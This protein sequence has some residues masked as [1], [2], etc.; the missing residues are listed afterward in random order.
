MEFELPPDAIMLRDML[1]K[2][3]Q[4]EAR[5]LE[6]KYFTSG[7]LEPKERLRLR[8]AIEQMGL[9]GLTVPEAYGGGLDTVSACLIEEELGK[10]FIPLDIGEVAAPLYACQ[11]GQAARYLEPA[12]A[13]ER[14]CVLAVREPGPDGYKPERW[15]TTAEPN[16][17]LQN[18][19]AGYTL[20]GRK[21]LAALPRAEDFLIVYAAS[22]EGITAFLLDANHPGLSFGGKGEVILEI[23]ECQVGEDALLGEPGKALGLGAEEAPRAWIRTGARYL[24]IVERLIEMSSEHARDWV[25]LGAA[26]A[27]RP[28]V[29]RML[30]E[31]RVDVESARWLVYHAAWLADTGNPDAVRLPAAQVRLATGEML[32]R[33]VDRATMLFAGPGPSDQIEPNRLVHSLVPP[34]ALKLALEQARAAIA[35]DMLGTVT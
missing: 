15:A 9:W 22:P 21:S 3:I 19:Q 34:Q 31:M 32:Q 23:A 24:G 10:T 8:Q 33:S 12:L 1:R 6:M 17:R 4:K 14:R 26:L 35:A 13:G 7:D 30:A 18:P 20:H 29:Q 5:P 27:V 2:F 28:A 11:N 25:S 16:E